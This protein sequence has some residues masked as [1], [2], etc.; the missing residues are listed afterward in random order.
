MKKINGDI[1]RVFNVSDQLLSDCYMIVN[2]TS[3]NNA[4]MVYGTLRENVNVKKHIM[5]QYNY[6]DM[7]CGFITGHLQTGK[8]IE[9]YLDLLFVDSHYQG[10]GIGGQLVAEYEDFCRATGA[11]RILVRPTTKRSEDF[12]AKHGFAPSGITCLHAKNLGR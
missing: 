8:V 12:Y 11:Q 2:M 10:A 1:I 5:F 6:R 4:M 3:P 7:V 9:A